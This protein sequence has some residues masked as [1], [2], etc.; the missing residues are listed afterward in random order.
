LLEKKIRQVA[1]WGLIVRIQTHCF[2]ILGFR[3]FRVVYLSE[4]KAQV[5]LLC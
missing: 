4:G 1:H 5:V 2:S 3:V